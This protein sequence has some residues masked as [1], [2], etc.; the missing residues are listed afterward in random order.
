M[1]EKKQLIYQNTVEGMVAMLLIME[2]KGL[3][4]NN[5]ENGVGHSDSAG[6]IMAFTD[7]CTISEK[8]IY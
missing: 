2:A 8:N 3:Q 7:K 4:F 6:S 5:S 1:Q